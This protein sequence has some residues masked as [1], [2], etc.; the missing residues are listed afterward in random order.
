MRVAQGQRNPRGAPVKR[1]TTPWARK[2]GS[3][4]EVFV[5]R[6]AESRYVRVQMGSFGMWSV[7]IPVQF[8][9]TDEERRTLVLK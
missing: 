6:D 7:L 1:L 2:I 5:N 4:E 3:A 8:V 9:E